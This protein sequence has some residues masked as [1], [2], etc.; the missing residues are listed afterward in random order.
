MGLETA[1]NTAADKTQFDPKATDTAGSAVNRLLEDAGLRDKAQTVPNQAGD[2]AG[3]A[4]N[5]VLQRPAGAIAD[6]G[7]AS[8]DG[9]QLAHRADGPMPAAGSALADAALVA[10]LA[11]PTD[12]D[13]TAAEQS[14]EKNTSKLISEADRN[15]LK[16]MTT[17]IT[18]G[19]SKAFAEAVKNAGADSGKLNDLVCEVNKSLEASHCTTKLDVT[20]DHKVLVSDSNEKTA[21]AFDPKTGAV[22]PKSVQYNPDGSVLVTAGELLRVDTEKTFKDIGNTAVNEI[23]GKLDFGPHKIDPSDFDKMLPKYPGHILPMIYGPHDFLGKP[24]TP[25]D[26]PQPHGRAPF[27]KNEDGS[28]ATARSGKHPFV[29]PPAGLIGGQAVDLGSDIYSSKDL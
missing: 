2:A 25:I 4:G 13:R 3:V 1:P 18:S 27:S 29:R 21:L 5:L 10:H 9:K 20:G 8:A 11:D 7:S 6:A 16:A 26:I 15:S 28:G 12:Q 17:A 19:D 14:L 24:E 23:N 22:E